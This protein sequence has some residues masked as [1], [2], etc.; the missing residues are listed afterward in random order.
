MWDFITKKW[1]EY[2]FRTKHLCEFPPARTHRFDNNSLKFKGSLLRNST[3]DGIKTAQS[4]AVL[5]Q[6]IKDRNGT[7][8]TCN[9]CKI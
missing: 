2:N 7:Q 4:L 9:I 6:K 8:Y 5:K 3:S 1:E